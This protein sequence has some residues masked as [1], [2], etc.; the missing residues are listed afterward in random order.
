MRKRNDAFAV[1]A[2][3]APVLA[4][5]TLCAVFSHVV[6]LPMDGDIA[7]PVSFHPDMIFSVV[8]DVLVTH[9][10]YYSDLRGKES[11]DRI[12][13]LGG[14]RL[15]LSAM[16]RG[17]DYPRDVGFNGLVIPEKKV[18]IGKTDALSSSLLETARKMGF[19]SVSIKQGYTAC[20][21]LYVP[22]GNLVCTADSGIAL[23]CERSGIDVVRIS[24][25]T[26]IVLPGY[27]CGF[28]GGC[29]GVWEDAV[30]FFGDPLEQPGLSPLCTALRERGI[31]A[32]SLMDGILTDYGG[33]R[34]FPLR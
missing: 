13:S 29:T 9:W 22:W 26:G 10:N 14:F 5:E 1:V 21:A 4:E 7:S 3:N 11:I 19:E 34:I 28:I 32:V 30:Y 23:A 6:R 31:D 27:D 24:C 12:C 20:S 18:L 25:D 16:D 8:G 17:A 33:I 2:G 15:V